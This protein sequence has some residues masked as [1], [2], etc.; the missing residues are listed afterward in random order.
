MLS[1]LISACRN[2]IPRYEFPL[3]KTDVEKFL[4]IKKLPWHLVESQSFRE[5]HTVY[6]LKT[7]EGAMI[8]I[9][10]QGFEEERSLCVQWFLPNDFTIERLKNF[11]TEEI[12]RLFELSTA[13]YG[14]RKEAK[15]SAKDFAEYINDINC[16][17]D[18]D[19]FWTYRI[20][21]I[22]YRFIM[23]QWSRIATKSNTG[24]L[25]VMNSK[26]FEHNLNGR[27]KVLIESIRSE[28]SVL[29]EATVNEILKMDSDGKFTNNE[30]QMFVVRGNV[31]DILKP[32]S[33]PK[34]LKLTPD[35]LQFKKENFIS[36]KL[37]DG[38]NSM[39]IYI[40]P[41]SLTDKELKQ[42]RKHYI[43]RLVYNDEPIYA[44]IYSTL[45][46]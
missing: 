6:T 20:G 12:P 25:S 32:E 46:E 31:K 1:V 38:T 23:S 27:A 2:S 9:E 26:A 24:S 13:L 36:G 18:N 28:N 14:N 35:N 3:S 45:V 29:H 30:V 41:T 10:S 42:D 17:K 15:S 33:R 7:E 19:I 8:F 34:L 4:E 16:S 43:S 21:D 39:E 11:Q 22:H 5:S 37:Q 44:L 40:Q